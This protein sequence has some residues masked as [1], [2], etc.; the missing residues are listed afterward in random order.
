M[1]SVLF[2]SNFKFFGCYMWKSVVWCCYIWLKCFLGNIYWWCVVVWYEFSVWLW[3]FF[4]ILI[5]LWFLILFFCSLIWVN[6]VFV[7]ENFWIFFFCYI[8]IDFWYMVLLCMKEIFLF[9][10]FC[11]YKVVILKFFS[12]FCRVFF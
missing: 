11:F 9:L 1:V 8:Y 12:S 7:G 5:F 4:D 6:W 10:N 3:V 2:C